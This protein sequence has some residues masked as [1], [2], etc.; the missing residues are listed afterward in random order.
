MTDLA[1]AACN[2]LLT[3]IYRTPEPVPLPPDIIRLDRNER[4][5]PCPQDIIEAILSRLTAPSLSQYPDTSSLYRKLAHHTSLPVDRLL[6]VPGSDAAFRALAHVFVQP[7]DSVAMIDPSYQ[8]YPVYTRMFGGIQAPVPVRPDLTVDF[9][10][11]VTTAATAKILWLAN[12]NQPSGTVIPVDRV[13]SLTREVARAGTL[14]VVDEAYYPFS[15]ATVIDQM[16]AHDNLVV[17]RTFSKAFGLAG[18]RLGFVAGPEAVVKAL[19]KVRA[20]FDINALAVV[21]G[22][23][24]LDHPEIVDGYV[25]ETARSADVL[26]ALAARHGLSAPVCATN[27][28]LIK[29]G[30]RFEPGVVKD[31]CRDHGYAICAPVGSGLFGDYIRVTV[32]TLD[33][34]QPFA[35]VLDRVL[36][37]LDQCGVRAEG[38]HGV[39]EG[40]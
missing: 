37:T 30:P 31:A 34:I 29:V 10:D 19:F 13:M 14:V 35:R 8:M 22:E 27:F 21:A 12:P 28:Q 17:V 40:P 1:V 11:L 18:V 6:L 5:G 33:V 38:T 4:V 15:G 32:G 25:Q 3:G 24:A 23:W 26:R 39:E 36:T 9:D 2:P 7:G 20:S 16:M